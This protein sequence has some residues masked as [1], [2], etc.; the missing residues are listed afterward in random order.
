MYSIISPPFTEVSKQ[1]PPFLYKIIISYLNVSCN[2]FTRQ[3]N[4]EVTPPRLFPVFFVKASVLYRFQNV[5]G[6]YDLRAVEV[7]DRP[8]YLEHAVV[9]SRRK[10]EDFK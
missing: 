10:P 4:S 1:P 7:G 3:A 5:L 2:H 6:I 9:G 8:R